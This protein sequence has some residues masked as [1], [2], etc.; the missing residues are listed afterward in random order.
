MQP[1]LFNAISLASLALAN[2]LVMAPMTRKLANLASG[3][4]DLVAFGLPFLAN[5]DL[6]TR[7]R[8]DLPLKG[9]EQAWFYGGGAARYTDYPLHENLSLA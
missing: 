9:P 7:Y 6:V 5:P 4:T 1:E 8:H 3:V 2:H